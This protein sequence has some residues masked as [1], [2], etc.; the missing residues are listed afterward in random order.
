[1]TATGVVDTVCCGC[2]S[3]GEQNLLQYKTLREA[4]REGLLKKHLQQGLS[5]PAACKA[6]VLEK[7]GSWSEEPN[8]VLALSYRK[9]LEKV[10]PQIPLTTIKRMGNYHGNGIDGFESAQSIRTRIL[11]GENVTDALPKDEYEFLSGKETSDFSKAERAILAY[12]RMARPEDLNGYY[13]MREGLASRICEHAD[14]ATLEQLFDRVKTKRFPHSAVRR[15]VLC[16][17]LRLPQTLP[18]ITYLRVL[19]LNQ[20]GQEILKR[21]KTAATLPVVPILTPQMRKDPKHAPLTEA[22]LRGD[23]FFAMTLPTPGEKFRDLT[24]SA[25]KV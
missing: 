25:K 20:R 19:A 23:E 10:A 9:A 14:A 7:G 13:G 3:D 22:Q 21:M 1:L 8:D 16:G 6:A 5:Y 2:E 12:Y 17:Y 18:E 11:R 4:E 15:A 24:V